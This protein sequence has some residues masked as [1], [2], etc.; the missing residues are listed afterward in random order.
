VKFVW[1][2]E[3]ET[4]FQQL[5]HLLTNAP[6]LNILDPKKYFLVYIDACK[7]GLHGVFMQEGQMILYE[8]RKLNDHEKRYATHDLELAS[9]VH[10][11]KIWRHYL[12]G[13][14]FVLMKYHFGLK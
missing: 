7:E 2:V 9:I 6:I 13:R 8:S 5:K 12:L 4:N 10:S 11:L 14:I 3:C 1:L